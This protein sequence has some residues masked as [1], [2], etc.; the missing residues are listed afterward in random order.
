MNK[1]TIISILAGAV[2]AL[3]LMFTVF[4]HYSNEL[5][6]SEH[7]L[8]VAM[9]SVATLTLKN[10]EQV[11]VINSY[12]L[13]KK[14]LEKYL[15]V[16]K[17]EIKELEKKVGKLS[18]LANL[19]GG[20][21]RDSVTI[22][23]TI[24]AGMAIRDTLRYKIRYNDQWLKL[25][26]NSVAYGNLV[27]TTFDEI[28]VPVPLQVGLTNDYKIWVKSKN[29]YLYI[30]NIEGAV[31]DGSRIN[32][33]QKKWGLGLQMGVG[34]HYGLIDKNLGVGPYVG[35]GISYNFLNF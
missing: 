12:I 1:K 28:S 3:A 7:N 32:K 21:R 35:V 17:T 4:R 20:V 26:G 24:P 33:K 22:H 14:E 27:T 5:E 6:T 13:E 31:I 30:N 25:S 18:Y 34:V 10:G 29:P 9:D 19:N 8:K 16:S 15:D 23:D 11:S 2:L